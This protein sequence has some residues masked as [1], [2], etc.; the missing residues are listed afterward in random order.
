LRLIKWNQKS[1][2]FFYQSIF[3]LSHVFYTFCFLLYSIDL[4][5]SLIIK[6]LMV[7]I[8]FYVVVCSQCI[9]VEKDSWDFWR[10]LQQKNLV[11]CVS[12]LGLGQI[13][14]REI[15]LTSFWTTHCSTLTDLI[16]L[17]IP[18]FVTWI[19]ISQSRTVCSSKGC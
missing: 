7:L 3:L 6:A 14:I 17:P 5:T 16:N 2:V 8:L 12:I 9:L 13:R 19:K 10:K 11:H 18:E 1:L 15:R 4:C